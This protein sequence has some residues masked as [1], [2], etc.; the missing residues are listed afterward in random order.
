M[1][2]SD[3]SSDVCSSDLVYFG[4]AAELAA[5]TARISKMKA[6][7]HALRLELEHLQS[8][9][10]P[11]FLFNAL[12]TIVAEIDERPAVASE[13]TRRLADYLRYSLDRQGQGLCRVDEEIEAADAYVRIQALQIGRASCR[14]RVGQYV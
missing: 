3:W 9:I 12:N 2:I 1:R 14:E 5:R 8:Q 4:V 11:H 7:T 6:E 10:E 13:M